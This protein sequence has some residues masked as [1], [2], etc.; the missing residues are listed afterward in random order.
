MRSGNGSR[1]SQIL[2]GDVELS[3]AFFSDGISWVVVSVSD[4]RYPPVRGS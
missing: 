3:V 2:A 1:N 4:H